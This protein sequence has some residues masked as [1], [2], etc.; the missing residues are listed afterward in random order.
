MATPSTKNGK[1]IASSPMMA[2][3][4]CASTLLSGPQLYVGTWLRWCL[5]RATNFYQCMCADRQY[6]CVVLR[7]A[8]AA[9]TVHWCQLRLA[10]P[11][12]GFCLRAPLVTA[13]TCVS[14]LAALKRPASLCVVLFCEACA[15]WKVRPVDRQNFSGV[16]RKPQAGQPEAEEWVRTPPARSPVE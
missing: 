1:K 7:H 15:S 11:S 5:S 6:G 13:S 10:I 4:S 14:G 3:G 9:H 16:Q 2:R 12:R 8:G